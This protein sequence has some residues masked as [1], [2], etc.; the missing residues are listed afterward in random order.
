MSKDAIMVDPKPSSR[1]LMVE[2][3]AGDARLLQLALRHNGFALDIHHVRDGYEALCYLR[4]DEPPWQSCARPDLILLD[5]K[6]PRLGGLE[7][8]ALIK[9]DEDLRAIPVVAVSSSVCEADVRS[10]YELGAAGYMLKPADLQEFVTMV[11][12]LGE[13][14]FRLVRLPHND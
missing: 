7:F 9:Q 13:Y 8:L 5:L 1:V 10:A 6:M 3:E 2:D 12:T 11:R 14:W 4:H